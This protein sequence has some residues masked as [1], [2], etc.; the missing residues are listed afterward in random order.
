[1]QSLAFGL[2]WQSEI[3]LPEFATGR[4]VDSPDVTVSIG[5]VAP[6]RTIVDQGLNR[7]ICADGV[8]FQRPC[9]PVIDVVG[10]DCVHITSVAAGDSLPPPRFFG[11]AVAGLL[12]LRGSVPLHGSAV[13]VDGRAILI[14]GDGGDGKSTL[15]AALVVRGARL[16]SDDLSALGLAQDGTPVLA[17]GRRSIRLHP[18]AIQMIEPIATEIRPS[19]DKKLLV[20]LPRVADDMRIPLATIIVL[21]GANLRSGR[22]RKMLSLARHLFRPTLMSALP[23][24]EKRLA[25][26]FRTTTCVGITHIDAP[27]TAPVEDYL[28]RADRLLDDH[29]G[30]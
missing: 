7:A 27:G 20:A 24:H 30:G 19:G 18:R 22:A 13:E 26:L 5:T 4:F 2:K 21:S 9:E 8:R 10:T 17:P 14:C 6:H 23:D 28:D 25:M 11:S 3:A 16:I 12:A 29:A 1:M 15:A